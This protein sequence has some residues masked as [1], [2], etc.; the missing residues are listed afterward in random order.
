MYLIIDTSNKKSLIVKVAEKKV[1]KKVFGSNFNHSEKLLIEVYKLLGKDLKK[2]KGIGVIS[3]PGSYTGLRVGIATANA[4]GYSLK[5]P[6]VDINKLE[7][8]ASVGL[9]FLETENICTIVSAIHDSIFA[10]EYSCKNKVIKQKRDFYAGKIDSLLND[11]KLKTYFLI[12]DR[13]VLRGLVDEDSLKRK[14]KDKFIGLK[15]VNFYNKEALEKLIEI[16]GEK[17]KNNKKYKIIKPLY[18]QKPNITYS[19]NK[20]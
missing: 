13:D 14:L 20:K 18:I 2:L 6:V 12:E 3:G 5:L 17:I 8:L 4:L 9:E 15:F 1:E 10:G 16:S 19:K 7:W 11:I